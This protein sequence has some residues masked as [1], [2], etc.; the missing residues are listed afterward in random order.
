M[1]E[2][3]KENKDGK[4]LLLVWGKDRSVVEIKDNVRFKPVLFKLETLL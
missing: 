1:P 4:I 3:R 2:M